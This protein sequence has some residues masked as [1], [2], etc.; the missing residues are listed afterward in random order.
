[1]PT[2]TSSP[3]TDRIPTAERAHTLKAAAI[4]ALLLILAGLIAWAMWRRGRIFGRENGAAWE[5]QP[6]GADVLHPALA[7]PNNTTGAAIS[8]PNTT[9]LPNPTA[10]S[11]PNLTAQPLKKP[12]SAIR[13]PLARPV[14]GAA[15]T[16]A[17]QR[18]HKR[19][20]R[21]ILGLGK[22]WRWI[23]RDHRTKPE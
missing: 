13:L 5:Y 12:S 10:V 6:K 7:K 14:P 20:R 1:M 22:L 8:P 11:T 16:E 4:M 3:V 9:S 2:M 23:R 15:T 19:H 17:A 18:R 21:D